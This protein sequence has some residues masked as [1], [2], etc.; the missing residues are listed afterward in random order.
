MKFASRYAS[1]RF[2]VEPTRQVRDEAGRVV[3]VVPGRTIQ[4]EQH[5][6]ETD[7]PDEI[8][9]LQKQADVIQVDEDFRVPDLGPEVANIMSTAVAIRRRGRRALDETAEASGSPRE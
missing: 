3:E 5:L 4:F 9:F 7:D 8:A 2:V 1:H 6:Y